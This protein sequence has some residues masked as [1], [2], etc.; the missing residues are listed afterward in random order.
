M[1]YLIGV[2]GCC[3]SSYLFSYARFKG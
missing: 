1:F 2:L 3:E